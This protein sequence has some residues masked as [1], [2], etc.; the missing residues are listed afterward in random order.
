MVIAKYNVFIIAIMIYGNN[1]NVVLNHSWL[2]LIIIS[3]I[4]TNASS[5]AKFQQVEIWTSGPKDE[6]QTRFKMIGPH[7][8]LLL[9]LF[10]QSGHFMP[11]SRC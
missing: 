7:F 9:S 1:E 2:L 8:L 5:N 3:L 6:Y 11:P 10:L 4:T